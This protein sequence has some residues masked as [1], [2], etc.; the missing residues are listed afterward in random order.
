MG[1]KKKLKKEI[2]EEL[3]SLSAVLDGG[4]SG[5]QNRVTKLEDRLD[6]HTN[7]V[8][9]LD[10]HLCR[11]VS[12]SSAA[13]TMARIVKERTDVDYT[14]CS[15]KPETKSDAEVVQE[16]YDRMVGRGATLEEL[17]TFRNLIQKYD[18]L[19]KK[20]IPVVKKI[21]GIQVPDFPIKSIDNPEKFGVVP[22][23]DFMK[24]PAD[25]I[26]DELKEK[27]EVKK[28]C[29]TCKYEHKRLI[30]EPCKYCNNDSYKWE[31]KDDG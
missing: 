27:V 11:A 6:R 4:I 28:D 31:A 8:A 18:A 13:K 22:K 2:R 3:D 23:P 30:E 16:I 10:R 19:E 1:K 20:E 9:D 5:L 12:D 25:R 15:E 29:D 17:D 7:W 24:G 21:N 26:A 14:K